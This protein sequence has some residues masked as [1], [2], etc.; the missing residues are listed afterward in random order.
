MQRYELWQNGHGHSFLPEH[1]N[2]AREMAKADGQ[3]LVWEVTAKGFNAA[4]QL[5]YDHLGFGTY[6]PMFQP[7]EPATP[8]SRLRTAP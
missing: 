7:T 3:T 1:N 4:H 2:Q 6:R 5:L 8:E